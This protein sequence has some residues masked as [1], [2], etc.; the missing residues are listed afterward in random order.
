[1]TDKY[2]RWKNNKGEKRKGGNGMKERII[3]I[4]AG[5]V[6]V[7]CL[8]SAHVCSTVLAK[9]SKVKTAKVSL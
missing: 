1:M 5:A 2:M 8:R 9:E 3:R 7:W 6:T 4:I